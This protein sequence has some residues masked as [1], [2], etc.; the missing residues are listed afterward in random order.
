MTQLHNGV[1][2]TPYFPRSGP[3]HSSNLLRQ[4]LPSR[5]KAV[6]PALDAANASKPLAAFDEKSHADNFTIDSAT[7]EAIAPPCPVGFTDKYLFPTLS[8]NERLRLTF[9]WYHTRRI[10][11]DERLLAEIDALVRSAQKVI[12]WEFASSGILNE[13]TYKTL[14]A[15]DL[16]LASIPR[17]EITCAHTINQTNGSVFM[18][19]DMSKDWRFKDSPLV[20]VTGMKSYAGTPLRLMADNGVEIPLGTLC[21][22]SNTVQEPLGQAQRESLVSIAE[23]ISAAIANHTHQRRLKER[24]DLTDL[25]SVLRLS[26]DVSGY[27]GNAIH[28]IQQAYPQ[29]HVSLKEAK[30]GHIA[31]EGRTSPISLSDIQDG[32]WEDAALIEQSIT[33]SNFAELQPTQTARAIIARCG[34]SE[35]YIVVSGLD[36]HHVFDDFDAW[37]IF[38]SASVIADTIESRVPREALAAKEKFLRGITQQLQNPLDSVLASTELL[39]ESMS[40]KNVTAQTGSHITAIRKSGQDMMRT[41]NSI[42]KYNTWS[43][44]TRRRKR[45][46]V[47]DLTCLEEEI[48]PEVLAQISEEDLHGVS[49]EFRDKL[50]VSH[51]MFTDADILKDCL[52]EVLLNSVQAVAG[53]PSGTVTVTMRTTNDGSRL[54]FDIEDNGSGIPTIHQKSIFQ[55]FVKV[56][57]EKSGA[58]LG[59]VLATQN[60]QS[61]YG[62]V[63]LVSSAP[64]GSHF[65]VIIDDRL[66]EV[67]RNPETMKPAKVRHLPL[68][69]SQ[70][71][72]SVTYRNF[73]DHIIRYLE[74]SGFRRSDSLNPGIII[75]DSEA[76]KLRRSYPS[77]IIL[78]LGR[79][80]ATVN[81]PGIINIKGPLHKKVLEDMIREADT[82]Y[83]TLI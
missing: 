50:P 53:R 25:L 43:G 15:G 59:L 51:T 19:T 52:R 48:L 72:S 7:G 22:A 66:I 70:K 35:K 68:T 21:V 8:P 83:Q 67:P 45:Q 80:D 4:Q 39:A 40:T 76:R 9:L 17:R 73:G 65:Q 74:I 6:G 24:Q 1:D 37:F 13:S 55:P 79:A 44:T 3:K 61:L 75:T 32:L 71:F 38:K 64:T 62:T 81:A 58:G 49:I 78:N 26:V 12:G 16:P 36:I 27:E 57:S 23:L 2:L 31:V 69:F 20:E 28:I 47:Y 82:A 11:S 63:R 34:N 5:P 54:I 10:E 77:A 60:A 56:N 29:T 14:A 41:V 46:A 33:T 18:V 42:K 30:A